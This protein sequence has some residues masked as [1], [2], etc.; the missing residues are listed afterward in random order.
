MR[1]MC[2]H[3][4]KQSIGLLVLIYLPSKIDQKYIVLYRRLVV[5]HPFC[6]NPE[7]NPHPPSQDLQKLHQENSSLQVIKVVQM[8]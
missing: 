3:S 8:W 7:E 5:A 6:F 4:S 2:P 1:K